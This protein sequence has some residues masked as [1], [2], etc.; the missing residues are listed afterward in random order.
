M[1]FMARTLSA[2]ALLVASASALAAPALTPQQCNDYPFVKTNKPLTHHQIMQELSEL[3]A[4]GYEPAVGN[5]PDYP[6]D[7]EA[8]EQRLWKEHAQ[9]CSPRQSAAIANADGPH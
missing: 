3:E 5:D 9:D 7:M 2:A 1:A 4:V 8:A 6:S